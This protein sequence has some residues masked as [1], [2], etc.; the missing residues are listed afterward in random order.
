MQDWA[1][2]KA[3]THRQSGYSEG[4]IPIGPT[5]NVISS[6]VAMLLVRVWLFG[7]SKESPF[8]DMI[9]SLKLQ[10]NIDHMI[11]LLPSKR[12]YVDICLFF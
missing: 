11:I 8:C 6:W 10:R 12:I 2:S 1:E 9:H 5:N 3:P 7:R 4:A